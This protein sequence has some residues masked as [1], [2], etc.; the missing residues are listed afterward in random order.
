[1]F[2]RGGKIGKTVGFP[3][4][5]IP[6]RRTKYKKQKTSTREAFYKRLIFQEHSQSGSELA[7]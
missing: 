5:E 2:S 3:G 4:C 1:M 7:L 6:A